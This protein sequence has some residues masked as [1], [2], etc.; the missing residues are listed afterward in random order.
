[1]GRLYYS[2]ALVK[3]QRVKRYA[4]VFVPAGTA[5]VGSAAGVA[6]LLITN[7]D[8]TLP[9]AINLLSAGSLL[10]LILT[11]ICTIFVSRRFPIMLRSAPRRTA[12]TLT[13]LAAKLAGPRLASSRSDWLADLAGTPEEGRP[14]SVRAQL[15]Y[16]SGLL[17]AA[18]RMRLGDVARW[19]GRR[20]N[21]VLYTDERLFYTVLVAVVAAAV[22][23]AVDR[24]ATAFLENLENLAALGGGLWVSALVLR[25]IRGVES[26]P[27]KRR[28]RDGDHLS[29]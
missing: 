24:G 6:V 19:G 18:V 10:G 1:V 8:V 25:R 20:L 21:W 26:V 13:G 23:L 28:Q 11:V 29:Q 12:W 14:L 27:W 3:R 4:L 16:A 22:K 15:R 9:Q 17:W 5:F 2:V 7:Q